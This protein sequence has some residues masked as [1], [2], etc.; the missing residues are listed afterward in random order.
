MRFIL[1]DQLVAAFQFCAM[2]IWRVRFHLAAAQLL[3][4]RFHG[5]DRFL[6]GK[7]LDLIDNAHSVNTVILNL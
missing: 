2:P 1:L 7:G 3:P 4:K 5:P 6:R